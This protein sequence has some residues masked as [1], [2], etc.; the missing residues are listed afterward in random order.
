MSMTSDPVTGTF[1][2]HELRPGD[3]KRRTRWGGVGVITAEGCARIAEANRKRARAWR[4]F[5]ARGGGWLLLC[6]ACACREPVKSVLVAGGPA[7]VAWLAAL[8]RACE[9]CGAGP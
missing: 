6:P 5:P 4:L 1:A 9:R 7:A 3:R 8:G 2:G